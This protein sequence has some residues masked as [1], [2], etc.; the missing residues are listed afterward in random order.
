MHAVDPQTL[1]HL[2]DCQ[3]QQQLLCFTFSRFVPDSELTSFC[4]VWRRC[5][6]GDGLPQAP[7]GADHRQG[8]RD[9][10]EHAEAVC[11]QHPGARTRAWVPS[12]IQA[13]P[14]SARVYLCLGC[15]RSFA[16]RDR[17]ENPGLGRPRGSK[18]SVRVD[19]QTKRDHQGA[20]TLCRAQLRMD[21]CAPVG[22]N[23]FILKLGPLAD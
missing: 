15:I 18:L 7:S 22:L 11:M 5:D 4:A 3:Q 2:A 13:G 20:C 6:A 9:S 12:V 14:F 19:K 21:S 10:E 16:V 8:R 17:M 1:P 23:E